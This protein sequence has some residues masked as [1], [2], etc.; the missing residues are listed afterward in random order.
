MVHIVASY[1]VNFC[2]VLSLLSAACIEGSSVAIF[3]KE[4]FTPLQYVL[5]VIYLF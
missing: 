2:V 5:F 1:G 3:W 4:L